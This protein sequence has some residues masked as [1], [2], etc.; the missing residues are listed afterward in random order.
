MNRWQAQERQKLA[1]FLQA[2]VGG[3]GKAIRRMLEKNSCKINGRIERFGSVWVEKGNVVEFAFVKHIEASWTT[4]FENDALKVVDKPAG[5][6]CDDAHCR[7][8]FGAGV[9]LVHRLDKDT[10]GALLL[11][12][13]KMVRDELMGLFAERL[14][15]KEYLALIDGVVREDAGVV[16]NFLAKKGSFQGQTIWGAAARGDLAITHWKVLSRGE[17]ETLVCCQPLTGRTHQIRVHLAG[18]N[19]PILGDRQYA[20]HFRSPLFA[21]RPMLHAHRLAF[22]Y[23]GQEIAVEAEVSQDFKEALQNSSIDKRLLSHSAI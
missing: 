10:T 19:H 23:Q 17:T 18:L 2:K 15:R 20:K 13:S 11:A 8:T 12:K 22:V 6:V 5:W 21:A 7:R 1:S 16:D 3:S 9:F 14:V 4:L